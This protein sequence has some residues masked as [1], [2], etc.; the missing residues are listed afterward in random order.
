MIQ[1]IGQVINK[2]V[3]FAEIL[4]FECRYVNHILIIVIKSDINAVTDIRQWEIV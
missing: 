1:A 3:L 4:V 2:E